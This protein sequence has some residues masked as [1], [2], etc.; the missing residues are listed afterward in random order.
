M[1]P[2]STWIAAFYCVATT[3]WRAGAFSFTN[4]NRISGGA[5][6]AAAAGRGTNSRRPADS[7]LSFASS[8]AGD[9]DE[10]TIVV[11]LTAKEGGNEELR[12]ALASHPVVGMMGV[13]LDV[14]EIPCVVT[15]AASGDGEKS[16]DKD[17][18]GDESEGEGKEEASV[19]NFSEEQ[20]AA[21]DEVDLACFGSASAMTSWLHN[22]DVARGYGD[23]DDEEKKKLGPEGNGD[24]VASCVD[25][26]LAQVCLG[27]GR[28]ESQKIY[29]PA[30]DTESLTW[31]DSAAM[32]IG[33]VMERKFWGGGW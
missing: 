10:N 15:A 20:L 27:T 33:D 6:F 18:E 7:L 31:V 13:K 17:C 5:T 3:A 19:V 30:K 4:H 21:I 26:D 8:D 29:Y 11:A 16:D 1:S 12:L 32:A 9:D 22:V 24:V 28:W 2:P 14:R 25:K 23:M